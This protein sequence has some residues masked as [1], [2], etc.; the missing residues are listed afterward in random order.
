[1][2][3]ISSLLGVS[4]STIRRRMTDYNLS[5]HATYSSISDAEVDSLVCDTH[6]RFPKWGVRRM[7]GFLISQ[8]VRIPFHRV[9]DSLR[10]VDPEGSF[11]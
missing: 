9:Q 1:M 4:V 7:Y 8:S 6:H 2:P 3:Q 11:L 10:H 5:V